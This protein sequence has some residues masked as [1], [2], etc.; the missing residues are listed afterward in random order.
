MG[1]GH[2]SSPGSNAMTGAPTP[3]S[4][5]VPQAWNPMVVA[6]VMGF[7]VGTGKACV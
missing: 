6:D 3:N 5:K 1:F 2:Q 7:C 4:K